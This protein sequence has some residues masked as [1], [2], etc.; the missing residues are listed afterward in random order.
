MLWFKI[1]SLFLCLCATKGLNM[2]LSDDGKTLIKVTND[3]LKNGEFVIPNTVTHIGEGTFSYCSSLTQVTIPDSVTHV[4]DYAFIK[5]SS[6]K[7]VSISN[8]L[9]HI[10]KGAFSFCSSLTQVTIP[11]SV[12]HIG[13]YAFY[14]CSSLT[15]VTILNTLDHIGLDAFTMCRN[16]QVIAIDDE[17]IVNYQATLNILPPKIRHLSRPYSE[18]KALQDIKQQ[19]LRSVAA[20]SMNGLSAHLLFKLLTQDG[21]IA[22]LP[23]ST[24][25]FFQRL[26]HAR[27]PALAIIHGDSH[28]DLKL[29]RPVPK[30]AEQMLTQLC[31]RIAIRFN[32]FVTKILLPT[33]QKEL[34]SLFGCFTTIALPHVRISANPSPK[35]QE[36]SVEE[37]GDTSPRLG[38]RKREN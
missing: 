14:Y 23:V 31:H 24:T 16:L 12:T 36:R 30:H 3:D 6:L 9:R 33:S 19:A 4:G 10:G 1:Q 18:L 37:I 22:G 25:S 32:P 13:D 29:G 34:D 20:L 7:R 11:G 35:N 28:P 15:Q 26:N 27:Q 8:S 5:C 21:K 2:Q 17:N 38:R